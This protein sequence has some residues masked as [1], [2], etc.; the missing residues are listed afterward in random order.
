MIYAVTLYCYLGPTLG[1]EVRKHL[2]SLGVKGSEDRW[3]SSSKSVS[4]VKGY[5]DRKYDGLLPLVMLAVNGPEKALQ[6]LL[7]QLLKYSFCGIGRN[8]LEGL[9]LIT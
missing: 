2:V 7:P 9:A 5:S 4:Q 3:S 8:E 1:G 6:W